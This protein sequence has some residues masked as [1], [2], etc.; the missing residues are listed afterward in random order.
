MTFMTLAP[1]SP[2]ETEKRLAQILA[3]VSA[4]SPYRQSE[5]YIGCGLP[6]KE[7]IANDPNRK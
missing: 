5:P 6:R 1:S 3:G 7:G 4:P 2:Y